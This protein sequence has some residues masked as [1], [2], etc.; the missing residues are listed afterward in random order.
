MRV[1]L[2]IVADVVMC[3]VIVTAT[4]QKTMEILDGPLLHAAYQHFVN[5]SAPWRSELAPRESIG[6][7]SRQ[8]S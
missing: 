8:R 4:V 7:A 2:L 5:F 6:Q 3:A 1:A